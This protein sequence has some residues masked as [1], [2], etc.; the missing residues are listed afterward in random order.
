MYD[1]TRSTVRYANRTE[2]TPG[3]LRL[4]RFTTEAV[5]R[6]LTSTATL[7]SHPELTVTLDR[8]AWYHRDYPWPLLACVKVSLNGDSVAFRTALLHHTPDSV[9]AR[10]ALDYADPEE[11]G[12]AAPD[13]QTSVRVYPNP[14]R[15]FL[16]VSLRSAEASSTTPTAHS[17]PITTAASPESGTIR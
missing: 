5:R 10:I 14:T 8:Y 17:R 15:D 1:G 2:E 4:P 12:G 6:R 7:D 9:A 11:D 13:S 16:R 3:V